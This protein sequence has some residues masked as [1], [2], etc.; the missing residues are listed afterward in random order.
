MKVLHFNTYAGAGGA[1]RAAL[2]IHES[3]KTASI[4]SY[5]F[6]AKSTIDYFD[7]LSLKS[8]SSKLN[9]LLARGFSKA[10]LRIVNFKTANPVLH[11]LNLFSCQFQPVVAQLSPDLIHLHWIA[12]EMLSIETIGKLSQ[13]LV[14]TLHDMW[15][16]CGA[17]HYTSDQ[18]WQQGYLYHNRP[19][20]E[21]GWDI[22]RWV[23]H[24]KRRSWK[25]PI[26]IVA[27]SEWLASC[28]RQSALMH[29][30]PV[31]VVPNPI[32]T[33]LWQPL[34]KALARQ[35]LHL[36]MQQPLILFGAMG[37]GQDPR[38]G[39]DL[40][41]E[42]LQ[43]LK[44][45]VPELELLVFGQSRPQPSPDFGFPI[46]YT[47]HLHDEMSL[48]ILYS[49]AD[50]MV[51]PSRQDNLPNTAVE[52]QACG[53]PVVAFNVGGLPDIVTHQQSGYLAEPFDTAELARGIQWVL[54][55]PQRHAQLCAQARANA[56]KKFAYPVVA[57]QYLTVYEEVLECHRAQRQLVR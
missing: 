40:L 35:I 1:A 50:V 25:R 38:K 57:K 18:R 42:A 27:P 7:V 20:Y 31:A 24:R 22:N 4:C 53:T 48:R 47:G 56:V 45:C 21:S 23:W 16:F 49:A 52:A 13:P 3:I 37:G 8:K 55:E 17:E 5:L 41:K 9:Y 32:N 30:W 34:D 51:V 39:F 10:L 36:P 54:K 11:S 26:H 46:H 12:G 33:E 29:S 43:H 15:A 6:T 28:V 44:L 14:W 2:R 19:A